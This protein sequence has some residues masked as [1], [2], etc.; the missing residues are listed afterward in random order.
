MARF[1]NFCSGD[2]KMAPVPRF[3]LWTKWTRWWGTRS[4]PF[5]AKSELGI[6]D[7][8]AASPNPSSSAAF[9]TFG[10]IEFALKVWRWVIRTGCLFAKSAENATSSPHSLGGAGRSRVQIRPARKRVDP[11]FDHQVADV[12]LEMPDCIA[13]RWGDSSPPP[14]GRCFPRNAG[15]PGSSIL[16]RYSQ[17]P[18]LTLRSRTW[19]G[20]SPS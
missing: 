13:Q 14:G 6:L 12:F 2:R 18:G 4:F 1:R 16:P 5:F 17:E 10:I 15:R 8:P 3:Y 19:T 20:F 11:L 7:V 9:G